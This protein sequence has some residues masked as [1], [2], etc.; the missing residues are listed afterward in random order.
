MNE[1]QT[2]FHVRALK[3]VF[4]KKVR[5]KITNTHKS[6]GKSLFLKRH[7][8]KPLENNIIV[9]HLEIARLYSNFMVFCPLPL[10]LFSVVAI[11]VLFISK[12]VNHD[13]GISWKLYL[14]Q[15][16]KGKRRL[17]EAERAALVPRAGWRYSITNI[18]KL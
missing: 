17:M 7:H 8:E 9:T 12:V 5:R 1:K 15:R 6:L 11:V 16:L 4:L 18:I 3:L 14:I 13:T 2:Q 10:F